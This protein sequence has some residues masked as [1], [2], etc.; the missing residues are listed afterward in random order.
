MNF[1]D[2]C[3]TEGN[4]NIAQLEPAKKYKSYRFKKLDIPSVTVNNYREK[5][6]PSLITQVEMFI[7]P[8]GSFET[9]D[10]RRYLELIQSYE[11]STNDMVLGLSLAD[12]IRI[13]FSDM[14]AATICD[15][16]PDIDLNS[17]RRYRCVAEYLLRQEELI[18]VRDC[19]GKLVKKI[20]NA[21]KPVVL[22]RGLPKL[23]ETLKN[24]DLLKFVKNDKPQTENSK[25]AIKS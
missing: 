22:Y 12:Q 19:N 24:S 25:Q 20:G 8:S 3:L 21:G 7:P 1:V 4:E 23:Y 6:V 17:K 10:L 14:K 18:K 15:R 5:L 9:P 2:W 11:T 16:F 13:A